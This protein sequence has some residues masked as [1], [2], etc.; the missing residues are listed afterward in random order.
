MGCFQSTLVGDIPL[1]E[2]LR[3]CDTGDLILFDNSHAITYLTKCCTR[4]KWDHVGMILRYS[5]NPD[6][7]ILIESAGCGVFLCY[8]KQRV[9]QCI[10][11][12]CVLGYRKLNKGATKMP[13]K[14]RKAIHDEAQLQVDKPYEDC[15]GEIFKAWMGQDGFET[16]LKMAQQ[17]GM[18]WAQKG[19]DLDALFCSEL[20]AHLLKHAK[21]LTKEQASNMY[22]PKDFS[23]ASNARALFQQPWSFVTEKKIVLT[24]EEVAVTAQKQGASA[25]DLG[26]GKTVT[27]K[28][29]ME[30]GEQ[31]RKDNLEKFKNA[32]WTA[33]TGKNGAG[34]VNSNRTKPSQ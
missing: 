24:Q 17:L 7:R 21:V 27:I 15:F 10:A 11:D 3:T 31:K 8:A 6:E 28:D 18:E 2:F 9:E 30:R 13:E 26:Q 32:N 34:L 33:M 1:H 4:S 25:V 22:L 5:D 20:V 16:P 12:G 19:E 23:A 14:V 29:M